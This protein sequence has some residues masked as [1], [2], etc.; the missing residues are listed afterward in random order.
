[1]SDDGW[2]QPIDLWALITANER[3]VDIPGTDL[4]ARVILSDPPDRFWLRKR[5]ADEPGILRNDR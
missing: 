1:M 2:T 4:Q 3:W 5:P